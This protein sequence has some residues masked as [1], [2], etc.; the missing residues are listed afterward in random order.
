M[1]QFEVIYNYF[2]HAL[3]ND[4]L[5][6]QEFKLDVN[7][8]FALRWD[9]KDIV[10]GSE[11]VSL[12]IYE[13]Y[14]SVIHEMIHIRCH[15]SGLNDLGINQYHKKDFLKIA[16]DLGFFVIKHN[17]QGWS[18]ISPIPPR[19]AINCIAVK[20]PNATRNCSL[21]DVLSDVD[22]NLQEL[23]TEIESLHHSIISNPPSKT[24]FLKYQCSCPEPH[25]SIRSGRRP[26]G[27]G[28]EHPDAMCKTCGSDYLCV[29]ELPD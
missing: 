19:N 13:F 3:F 17:S 1:R 24:F 5:P 14:V 2:N 27:V 8:K 10:I 11:F 16:L 28:M 4:N 22:C 29:S 12:N 23:R 20:A 26:L 21:L 18:I 15:Q 25:N 6:N 7:K 9:K